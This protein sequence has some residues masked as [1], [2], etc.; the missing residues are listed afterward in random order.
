MLIGPTIASIDVC[1]V[2]PDIGKKWIVSDGTPGVKVVECPASAACPD[3][4][5]GVVR[6]IVDPGARFVITPTNSPWT[7]R[8]PTN[9]QLEVATVAM[10]A[11]AKSARVRARDSGEREGWIRDEENERAL[12]V[13][14][15]E[16][17]AGEAHQKFWKRL[18]C[19][20]VHCAHC[21][22][23]VCPTTLNALKG[24]GPIVKCN[25]L[26]KGTGDYEHLFRENYAGS[27][28]LTEAMIHE[29]PKGK[30]GEPLD[31]MFHR[32]H[33]ITQKYV[34]EKRKKEAKQRGTLYNHY[35]PKCSSFSKAQRGCNERRQESP[36][37]I[38]AREAVVHDN[39]M[40]LRT[41]ALC[42]IHHMVGDFFS[43]E[44]IFPTLAL[45]FEETKALLDLPGVFMLTWD[46]CQYKEDYRHRQCLITNAPWLAWISRDCGGQILGVHEHAV[47]SGDGMKTSLVSPFSRELV[48]HWA[49]LFAAF[50]KAP[51]E[52]KCPFC[53]DLAGK[54][55]IIAPKVSA[56]R[57]LERCLRMST[58]LEIPHPLSDNDTDVTD[59]D[60][61]Q[62]ECGFE[63]R[64]KEAV[65]RVDVGQARGARLVK[66]LGARVI[67]PPKTKFDVKTVSN[68]ATKGSLGNDSLGSYLDGVIKKWKKEVPSVESDDEAPGPLVDESSDDELL[69]EYP[70]PGDASS[71]EGE[72]VRKGAQ[73][74]YKNVGK[75]ARQSDMFPKLQA[76][77]AER[78][79]EIY[80]G[81]DFPTVES[82]RTPE[83]RERLLKESAGKIGGT[84]EEQSR[85]F[86]RV[87]ASYPECFWMDGCS[88]PLIR[89]YKIRFRLKPGAKPVARQ[90]IPMSPY[91]DLRVEFHIEEAV[92]QGKLRKIDVLTEPIPDWATPVFI[93]DQD[94]KGLLGRMV[95]AYGPVNKELEISCFPSA[96]PQRAFDL[97]AFKGHHSVVDAI[98]GY[99]QF[100]ID[101]Q[102]KR[103]LVICARSGMYEWTR[104]PFGPA[105]A[106]AEMQGYVAT[107]FGNLRDKNGKEFCTPCMD[108]LKVSS[109]T[110]DE[111]CEHMSLLCA[112]AVKEGFEFKLKKGQFNQHEIV[113]W[114]CICDGAGKR[115]QPKKIEQL[116]QWPVP[117]HS[118]GVNSFLCFVNYLREYMDPQWTEWERVLKPFRKKGCEFHKVWKK[119]HLEAFLK[120]RKSLSETVVLRHMDFDAAAH[121]EESG[122]PLEIFIDASD[123]GWCAT[124]TQ[125]LV[126]H[127]TPKIIAIIAKGFSD[128]QQRW[129]AMERELY[130]LWQGVVGHERLIKGF[131]TFCYID[132]KNNLFSEAQ[133]DNRRRSKKMSNWALELQ[134]FDIVRVWIRGEANILSDAPS[135]APWENALARHLPIPDMPV[136]DLVRKMYRDPDGLDLL[137][138][139]RKLAMLGQEGWVPLELDAEPM[140]VDYGDEVVS[141]P[142]LIIGPAA[143]DGYQTPK[144]GTSEAGRWCGWLGSC[145]VLWAPEPELYPRFP[146]MVLTESQE[147]KCLVGVEVVVQPVPTDPKAFPRSIQKYRD[148]KNNHAYVLRWLRSIPFS[149]GTPRASLWFGIDKLGEAEAKRQSWSYFKARYDV[150]SRQVTDRK[151]K[152]DAEGA[153]M[154]D[155]EKETYHHGDENNSWE[156][157]WWNGDKPL[158]T[159]LSIATWNPEIETMEDPEEFCGHCQYLRSTKIGNKVYQCLGHVAEDQDEVV[160]P[161]VVEGGS[162]PSVPLV[163]APGVEV[164][165][166]GDVI[167][168]EPELD[169]RDITDWWEPVIAKNAWVR[170]HGKFR[171]SLFVPRE[172]DPTG[173]ELAVLSKTRVTHVTY[174]DGTLD[175]VRDTW[176]GP[177]EKRL[178]TK[179]WTGETWFFL[180]GQVP[181]EAPPKR[182]LSMRQ[183]PSSEVP[184]PEIIS[185]LHTG[186]GVRRE[187]LAG[188]L[189]AMGLERVKLGAAQRR[190]PDFAVYYVVHLAWG[191]NKNARD[192][193]IELKKQDSSLMGVKKFDNVLQVALGY[194]LIN[195]VLFKRMYDTTEGEV[196]LRCAV[197]DVTAS[198][199]EQA[200]QGYRPLSYRNWLLMEYHNGKL[201]GHCG[202]ERTTEMLERDFFWPG[203]REDV[204]RWCRRCQ[205]C[206]GERAHSGV[207]AWTRT[208]LF[209][210]P[211]RVLQ[212][213]T[214]TCRKS[215]DDGARYILTVIDCFSRWPW[216]IPIVERDATTIAQA[217][218]TK[219]FLGFAMFPAVL[220]S[221]N[222]LEFTG[223]VASEL[224]RLLE[225][226]HITGS[227]YHPQSQGMVESMHKTLNLLVR[228][229]A[230]D[231][232]EDWELYLPYAECILRMVPLKA[233]GGRC[234]YEIVTG[235]KPKLPRALDPGLVV[236]HMNL[237]EYTEKIRTHFKDVYR[238]V[239]RAQATAAEAAADEAPG[240]LSSELEVGDLTLVRREPTVKREGPLRFQ[241]RAYPEVYKISKKLGRHTFIVKS[242][243]EPE[244]ET[245]FHQ[246]IHAERLIKV[247]MPE[248]DIDPD[249]PRK[250]EVHDPAS[251]EWKPHEVLR[252]SVDGR[253]LLRDLANPVTSTWTDLATK[254]YRWIAWVS[255]GSF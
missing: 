43:L 216:L 75:K 77:V 37:G 204:R 117:D 255:V 90:P 95:C 142:A 173:P 176:E 86:D 163:P 158:S 3:G 215:R 121:P 202:R 213:D 71:S 93:V 91:D 124:L 191:A 155:E 210:R 134:G 238:D 249:Q 33:D 119:E 179:K 17:C 154:Y 212:Y 219:V 143:N 229:L 23:H 149:D 236:Q 63:M 133:L 221:D 224:N 94:A 246:P 251:D 123:F 232:P 104:M 47:L 34:Y 125:R 223:E 48:K 228:G 188:T 2:K 57:V 209:S 220:R 41:V 73:N 174:S 97:A 20:H 62:L 151:A 38:G 60:E 235:M 65:L 247:D 129:S 128:V 5:T 178:L 147:E 24:P 184:E 200:G 126:P 54:S 45:E 195:S 58:V 156:F 248:L 181:V 245:P 214:V 187:G 46:N 152:P 87:I 217:L 120:I 32:D 83:F 250:L 42:T 180:E 233:L 140:G 171:S 168:P 36:Y 80:R 1:L 207:S 52:L 252:F 29:L 177:A 211:F 101:D 231:H 44:H 14:L 59:S 144:F 81:L 106:P 110:F 218:M 12:S 203:M 244:S 115:A 150:S 201:A 55:K 122:R 50:C 132:H 175:V 157:T 67:P 205:Q 79:K 89:N 4:K 226:K 68:A 159:K 241:C 78:R 237:S 196:Q 103:I 153:R 170:F 186:A 25:R 162:G 166:G 92:S 131:K 206:L 6:V 88:A 114:G 66:Q 8:D 51:N 10:R 15:N 197:P 31:K 127:G 9:E 227:S 198:H 136:R 165:E 185:A 107:K 72:P 193:L 76:E 26:P 164:V 169:P 130:A 96:D 146:V 242:V 18:A 183:K 139:E 240:H 7:L 61:E 22:G 112:A 82:R 160:V 145:G 100:E 190:C 194:E 21:D 118:D 189:T 254:R 35:S 85:F 105:P 53:A 167:V 98:W 13:R 239:E 111:H 172:G 199:Y 39:V 27:K 161:L 40:F 70:L 74:S 230:Q 192:A 208:E 56:R 135:R 99:N 137:V 102:T 234:A 222:A 116:N 84:P 141:D 148:A 113:F 243:V 49:R 11:G 109:V 28:R 225:I 16:K 30:V 182:R 253:V 69:P 19:G 64:G 138:M 108:D